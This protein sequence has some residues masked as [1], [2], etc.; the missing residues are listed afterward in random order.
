MSG[1][2]DGCAPYGTRETGACD[3]GGG[4]YANGI[5]GDAA[6]KSPWA[7]PGP[8][9]TV[10]KGDGETWEAYAHRLERRIKAQRDHIKGVVSLIEGTGN[11]ADRKKV[12][13]LRSALATITEKW[14]REREARIALV[15]TVLEMKPVVVAA[16]ALWDVLMDAIADGGDVDQ[17]TPASPYLISAERFRESHDQLQ[18][19]L[20]PFKESLDD[21]F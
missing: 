9:A 16:D 17:A 1:R 5:G 11:R 6:D 20:R 7:L 15:R 19:A 18:K 3:S 10:A 14:N 2:G 21:G 13:R 4:A 8:S 12:E